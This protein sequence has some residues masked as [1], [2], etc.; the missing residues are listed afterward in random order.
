MSGV[1]AVLLDALGTLVHLEP[2]APRLR[3]ALQEMTGVDVGAATARRGF[4]AEIAHYLANHMQAA[5]AASLDRLRD[6]CAAVVHEALAAPGLDR[7]TVRRAM[8]DSLEFT[9]FADAA[10]ALR[11]LRE[12]G[13]R[14]VAVSNWD[15]SLPDWL[16]RAGLGPLLDGAISSAVV[17][18]PKPSPA[19]FAAAL[20]VA[21]VE[22]GEA[23][24]VGD[25]LEAD[26]EGASAAG[27]RAVLVAREGD[28]PPGVESVR[29]LSE[30]VPLI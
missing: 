25:S 1:K 13:L 16:D 10:P 28:A 9:A 2:P 24:H 27:I 6:D 19:V 3:A 8:L 12:R 22:P 17:G 20:A 5:D 23:L 18:E 7:D 29:S 26:V 11:T 4:E 30:L 15:C 14:L 21:G